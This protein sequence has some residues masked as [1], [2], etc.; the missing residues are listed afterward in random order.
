MKYTP[1]ILLKALEDFDETTIIQ[2]SLEDGGGTIV[3]EWKG[4]TLLLS[5]PE[6]SDK[7]GVKNSKR[8]QSAFGV[9]YIFRPKDTLTKIST[10]DKYRIS[11]YLTSKSDNICSIAYIEKN[12]AF[13]ISAKYTRIL[14]NRPAFKTIK[15]D[16]HLESIRYILLYLM[17]MCFFSSADLAVMLDEFANEDNNASELVKDL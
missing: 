13:K 4:Y 11:N 12:D 9:N 7:F 5:I 14:E 2:S 15:E 17:G 3:Y 8:F 16:D 6:A 1:E 10:I